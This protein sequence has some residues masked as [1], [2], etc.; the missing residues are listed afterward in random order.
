[1][2]EGLCQYPWSYL[3]SD[4]W[5]AAATETDEPGF[6]ALRVVAALPVLPETV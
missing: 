3:R 4:V 1:M 5:F 6:R 2:E